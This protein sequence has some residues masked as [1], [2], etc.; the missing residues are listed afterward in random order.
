MNIKRNLHIY[1]GQGSD[2]STTNYM[3]ESRNGNRI[4]YENENRGSGQGTITVLTVL[5]FLFIYKKNSR[6]KRRL[7]NIKKK[8]EKTTKLG[9]TCRSRLSFDDPR[10]KT[11]CDR[12]RL[13]LWPDRC[14]WC[15][16]Q[17]FR[18][19]RL[20]TENNYPYWPFFYSNVRQS[21]DTSCL[22]DYSVL[23][24]LKAKFSFDGRKPVSN[25]IG[26]SSYL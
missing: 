5:R 10:W 6:I 21:C 3:K 13:L 14:P 23:R 2:F 18:T 15:H 22:T 7:Q 26:L 17:P 16:W 1:S 25:L 9:E 24:F 20:A 19:S 11:R 8:R 12:T 4:S